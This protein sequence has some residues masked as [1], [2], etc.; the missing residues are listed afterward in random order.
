MINDI[1][2]PISDRHDEKESFFKIKLNKDKQLDFEEI[3]GNKR[4]V[5]MEIGVGK[6]EFI[7]MYSRFHPERNFIGI[8]LK[9]KRI[10]TTLKKLDP[11]KN[12]NVRILKL[13]VDKDIKNYVKLSSIDEIIVYHPDP[14]PKTRHHKHRLFQHHF[15]DALNLILKIG[16]Y[17]KIST[18]DPNYAKWIVNLF[19]QREDFETMYDEGYT[20]IA[21]DDHFRTFFDDIKSK[22]GFEPYFMFYKKSVGDI[23]DV[24][25]CI[26]TYP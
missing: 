12:S 20:M 19:G 17:I 18:D 23:S 1:V 24:P 2:V 3:F 16:G 6:G 25:Q 8:E 10:V 15:I 14:W 13:F 5:T 21:P 9:D 11:I 4:P 22:E 7:A 26:K